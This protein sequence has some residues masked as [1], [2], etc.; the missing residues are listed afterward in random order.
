M[1]TAVELEQ[2]F[3]AG[4]VAEHTQN[5]LRDL[6]TEEQR[7]R[8]QRDVQIKDNCTVQW[9]GK[10]EFSDADGAVKI[11]DW[12]DF[13]H[14]K[15][16]KEPFFTTGSRRLAQDGEETLDADASNFDTLKHFTVPGA[17][18]V[19]AWRQDDLGFYTGARLYLF[20]L[21]GV[22]TGFKVLIYGVF[23]GPAV[24]MG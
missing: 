1:P 3:S 4:G 9:R 7:G 21:A 5:A 18:M 17:G 24:L 6:L 11:T 23:T 15:F 13:G 22:P 20:A 2:Y 8:M 19:A 12:I 16:I 14:M 10:A